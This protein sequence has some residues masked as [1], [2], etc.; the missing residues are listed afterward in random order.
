MNEVDE[1]DAGRLA[2]N[3][4]LASIDKAIALL[5]A[6]ARRQNSR[7]F[8]ITIHR[9]PFS[10]C[11]HRERWALVVHLV[12]K[13]RPWTKLWWMPDSDLAAIKIFKLCIKFRLWRRHLNKREAR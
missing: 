5:A 3:E 12:N 13:I 2:I 1:Q 8:R 7:G 9:N 11:E 6:E 10:I 4:A